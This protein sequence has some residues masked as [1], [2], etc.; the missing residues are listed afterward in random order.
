MSERSTGTSG[1]ADRGVGTRK[2]TDEHSLS[3]EPEKG[4]TTRNQGGE[5]R[6][7]STEGKEKES[8]RRKIREGFP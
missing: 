8:T 2:N 6:D 3:K 1:P 4:T 5:E 7:T